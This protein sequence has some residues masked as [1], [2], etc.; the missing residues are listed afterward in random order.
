[1]TATNN[2]YIY[3]HIINIG[4]YHKILRMAY[5][6]YV[7][8]YTFETHE[9]FSNRLCKYAYFQVYTRDKY[10]ACNCYGYGI[11]SNIAMCTVFAKML[12][13]HFSDFNNKLLN[14]AL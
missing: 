3:R 8:S 5:L 10:Y 13:F 4:T 12:H 11:F 1:M 14:S 6:R 2:N 7:C 9:I